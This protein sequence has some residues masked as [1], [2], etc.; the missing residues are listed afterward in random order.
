MIPLRPHCPCPVVLHRRTGTLLTDC[1]PDCPSH[2][3]QGLRA[4][5]ERRALVR[6]QQAWA[7]EIESWSR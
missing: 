6:L 1:Q 3:C 2:Y 7:A 4:Y 5:L